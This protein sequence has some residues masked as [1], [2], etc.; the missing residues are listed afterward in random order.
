[1]GWITIDRAMETPC[2]KCQ[3]IA[4]ET[5]QRTIKCNTCAFRGE[6]SVVYQTRHDTFSIH[7]QPQTKPQVSP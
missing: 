2:E 1:M 6:Y 5:G 7:S 3:R 4:K